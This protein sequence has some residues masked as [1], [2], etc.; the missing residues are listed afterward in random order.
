MPDAGQSGG[1][2]QDDRLVGG[3]VK[4]KAIYRLRVSLPRNFLRNTLV[5]DAPRVLIPSRGTSP[6]GEPVRKR[7]AI[8]RFHK[9]R[10]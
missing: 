5:V 3:Q 2:G 1:I 6:I 7:R 4:H 9:S 8:G 10:F